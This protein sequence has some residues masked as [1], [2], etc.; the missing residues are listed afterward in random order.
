M[1]NFL[2]VTQ[3]DT[4]KVR[5]INLAHVKYID[6]A[7]KGST[8]TFIDGTRTQARESYEELA[9]AIAGLQIRNAMMA[10]GA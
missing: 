1:L 7:P 9:E 10:Q 6:P 2:S 5:G 4:G 3:F 8:V